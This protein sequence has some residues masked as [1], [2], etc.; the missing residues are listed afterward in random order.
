MCNIC[1]TVCPNRANIAYSIDP[2][3]VSHQRV[4]PSK[5]GPQIEDLG[6]IQFLQ[7]HQIINIG[8]FCNECGNCS[9]FCPTNGDP[10]RIKPTF[11][12]T[13]DSFSN[14]DNGYMLADGA[15]NFK[16]KDGNETIS[17]KNGHL[18]YE[19]PLI[20][21]KLSQKTFLIEDVEYISNQ[22]KSIDLMHGVQMGVMLTALR[23]CAPLAI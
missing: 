15:L 9:T 7:P 2:V 17:L 14:A 6:L 19:T 10:S 20:R 1:T 4:L 21:V 5:S 16:N 13:K 12:L 8:D 3:T 23:R 18:T 22:A 11:Y